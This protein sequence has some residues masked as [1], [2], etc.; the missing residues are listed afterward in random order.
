M[1]LQLW[2]YIQYVTVTHCHCYIMELNNVLQA[3][4]AQFAAQILQR[5]S[6]RELKILTE[7]VGSQIALLLTVC[8]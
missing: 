4:S 7:N 3:I 1:T 8:K 2:P 5:G 6:L